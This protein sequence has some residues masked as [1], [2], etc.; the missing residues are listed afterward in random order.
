MPQIL[1][2]DDELKLSSLLARI[3]Q[4]E[5][6]NVDQAGNATEGLK[7]TISFHPEVII[8]D[9]HLPDKNGLELIAQLKLNSPNSEIIVFTAHGNI[10]DAIL[11]IRAGAF[12]YLTKGDDQ[13][14]ILPMIIRAIEKNQMTRKIDALEKRVGEKYSIDNILGN[15]PAIQSAIQLTRKV[16]TL[17]TTVLITGETGTGKEVFAQSIHQ[18]SPRKKYNFVPVNCSSFS[19]E[20]LESEL[21]GHVAGSFTGAVKDKPGLFEIAHQ[22]TL[23]LDEIG[24]LDLG[25]QVKLLRLLESQELRSVGSHRVEKVDVRIIA[26][27]NRN[28]MALV[29]EGG[30]RQDLFERLSVLPVRVP[31]LRERSEDIP[32]LAAG[33]L[34]RM[35][36]SLENVDFSCLTQFDWP[37]NTRQLKNFLIRAHVLTE[38]ALSSVFLKDL[39]ET[40]REKLMGTALAETQVTGVTLAEIER[41]VVLER[42]TRCHGNR[43]RAAK[44][45]GIAKSTLHEKLRKWKLHTAEEAW[46]LY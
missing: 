40:E 43:K 3:I 41:Q 33:I 5:G 27:T 37:G 30:F 2:I 17:D 44:E 7:K 18:L 36:A 1:I 26:A 14:R 8:C 38:G 23:F 25:L 22:G 29:K 42:L 15:S 39:L 12:D 13:E 16:A 24:E 4:R 31:P 6:F 28:L 35:G 9:V 20:L 46:P 34:G 19:R 21:F 10:Q 11:A 45:L 32:F